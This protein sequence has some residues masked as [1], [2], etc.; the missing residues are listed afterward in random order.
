MIN[1][2]ERVFFFRRGGGLIWHCWI[3]DDEV[4][5]LL[6]GSQWSI[7]DQFTFNR[8]VVIFNS[9]GV[10]NLKKGKIPR[11]KKEKKK[12]KKGNRNRWKKM[13]I[14][15][16]APQVCTIFL[17]RFGWRRLWKQYLILLH[18]CSSMS[19]MKLKKISPSIKKKNRIRPIPKPSHPSGF[20]LYWMHSLGSPLGP[21]LPVSIKIKNNRHSTQVQVHSSVNIVVD[22]RIIIHCHCHHHWFNNSRH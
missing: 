1:L 18:V 22:H 7:A 10:I 17:P 3:L 16:N 14:C 5:V 6:Q 8:N 12:R 19:T 11:K 2:L 9:D 13:K 20:E 15:R 4:V 21:H